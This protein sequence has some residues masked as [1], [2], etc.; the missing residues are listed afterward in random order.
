VIGSQSVSSVNSSF[1]ALGRQANQLRLVTLSQDSGPFSN[2]I[3]R[4]DEGTDGSYNENR[5]HS[6]LDW[7]TP[8]ESALQNPTPVVVFL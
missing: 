1:P 5:H 8:T 6:A 3:D 4:H 7:A 2:R